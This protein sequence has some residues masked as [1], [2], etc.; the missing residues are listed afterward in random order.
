M[1]AEV[2][3]MVVAAEMAVRAAETVVVAVAVTTLP[4]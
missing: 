3:A 1:E 2:V 4:Q